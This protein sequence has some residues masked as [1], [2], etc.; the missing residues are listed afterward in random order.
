MATH[1]VRQNLLLSLVAMLEQLLYHIISKHIGHQLQTV[2]LDFSEN[3]LLLITVGSFKLL[4]DEPRT[5]L[6]TTELDN[7][8]IDILELIAL[9]A[10]AVGPEFFQ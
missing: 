7:M 10:F 9:I 1:L 6:I 5:V 2:R 8:V 4:L 3:L